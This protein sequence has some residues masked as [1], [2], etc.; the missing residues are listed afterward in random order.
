MGRKKYDRAIDSHIRTLNDHIGKL[1]RYP[2]Q[3]TS[4]EKT[5]RNTLREL[6]SVMEKS[7]VARRERKFWDSPNPRRK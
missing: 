6:K 2:R 7:G 3:D 1:A 4:A 5:I